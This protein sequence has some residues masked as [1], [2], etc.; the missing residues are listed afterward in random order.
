M[1]F[2]RRLPL[3][4]RSNDLLRIARRTSRDNIVSGG[5]RLNFRRVGWSRDAMKDFE[6]GNL[7]GFFD[8]CGLEEVEI[9]VGLD[10]PE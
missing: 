4:I 10:A 1:A 2:K 9:K 6:A 3:R 7:Q 5:L 8:D